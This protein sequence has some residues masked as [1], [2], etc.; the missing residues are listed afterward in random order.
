M[1][2]Q[3]KAAHWRVK[4]ILSKSDRPGLAA[5]EEEFLAQQQR[6]TGRAVKSSGNLPF[7][8]HRKDVEQHI[9][10]TLLGSLLKKFK[11][12]LLPVNLPVIV[13]GIWKGK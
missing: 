12:S 13:P 1:G 11:I 8:S 3:T 6:G 10:N 5:V 7:S 2:Q 9:F 4:I